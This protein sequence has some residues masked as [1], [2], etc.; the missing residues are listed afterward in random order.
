M[1]IEGMRGIAVLLVVAFHVGVPGFTGGYVGVD[2]F[3]VLSGYLITSLFLIEWER[4]GTIRLG[5]FWA[6]RMTSGSVSACRVAKA[7][8]ADSASSGFDGLG[9]MNPNW[10]S[11]SDVS[12]TASADVFQTTTV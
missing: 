6:R 2:V 12:V 10:S 3:F 7:S 11:I 5:A 9:M 4:T 8:L 1:D